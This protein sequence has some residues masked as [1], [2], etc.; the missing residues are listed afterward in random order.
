VATAPN[1]A[2]QA[3]AGGCSL[4]S[5]LQRKLFLASAAEQARAGRVDRGDIACIRI[6]PFRADEA[7]APTKLPF[8]I[9]VLPSH[10]Q[11]E[12]LYV[13]DPVGGV[14]P[15]NTRR[16]RLPVSITFP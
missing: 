12:H 6:L 14:F 3:R 4:I 16:E 8:E 15:M 9:P 10:H 11:R 13:A 7:E 1:S 2:Y 5:Q